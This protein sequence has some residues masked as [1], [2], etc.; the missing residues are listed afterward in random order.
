[1]IGCKKPVSVIFRY[2]CLSAT[3]M[4]RFI[5]VLVFILPS[6]SVM[7]QFVPGTGEDRI[8]VTPNIAPG[9]TIIKTSL[10][11][12]FDVKNVINLSLEYTITKHLS[13]EP[14]IGYMFNY[15][16]GLYKIQPNDMNYQERFSLRYYIPENFFN[17]LYVGPVFSYASYNFQKGV[18]RNEYPAKPDSV[19]LDYS[20]PWQYREQDFG[21]YLVVG[22]QPVIKRH[23]VIDLNGGFGAEYQYFVTK[24]DPMLKNGA[25]VPAPTKN[26]VPLGIL[27]LHFGYVF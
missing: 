17:G 1:M 8:V 10:L 23:F 3:Y 21:V 4:K 18:Y 5:I 11:S 27:S 16:A 9:K 13:V 25:A 2:F 12:P 19:T 15:F 14:E 26:I 22:I 7:A 6:L 24:F 20:N